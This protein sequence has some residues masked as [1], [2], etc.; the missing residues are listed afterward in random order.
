MYVVSIKRRSDYQSV[1]ISIAL[2]SDLK[3]A[4]LFQDKMK[5]NNDVTNCRIHDINM[6][7]EFTV[8]FVEADG[9]DVNIR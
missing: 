8:E 3:T 5:Q 4:Q 2:F 6:D 1:E 7:E 9:Y